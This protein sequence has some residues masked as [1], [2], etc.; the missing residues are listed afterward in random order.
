MCYEEWLENTEIR[1][2]I[3]YERGGKNPQ[4]IDPSTS[5]QG[6]TSLTQQTVITDVSIS[7]LRKLQAADTYLI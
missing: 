7:M 6:R 2:N 3:I 5:P 1:L 4:T